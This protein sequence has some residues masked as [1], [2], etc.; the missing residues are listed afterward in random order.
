MLALP[1]LPR[2]VRQALNSPDAAGWKAAMD[3]E[4]QALVDRGTWVLVARPRN[5][6]VVTTKWIFTIKTKADGSF[7]R[8]KARLVARG[9]TQ[10]LGLDYGETYAPVGRYATARVLLAIACALD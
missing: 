1:D 3:K 7:E 8:Y 9:F 6:N 10:L 4:Y 2:T 5:R